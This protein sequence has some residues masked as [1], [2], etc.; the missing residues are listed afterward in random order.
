MTISAFNCAS[1]D[2]N[3]A[4]PPITSRSNNELGCPPR[5]C[6]SLF[7]LQCMHLHTGAGDRSPDIST[8]TWPRANK[9]T[10]PRLLNINGSINALRG[11]REHNNLP[12]ISPPLVFHPL[13]ESYPLVSSAVTSSPIKTC[14]TWPGSV[15]RDWGN[16][17]RAEN[18]GSYYVLIHKQ[19]P[20][21]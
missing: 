7:Q 8:S 18:I 5:L 21:P 13:L 6:F 4:K 9:P 1:Q 19:C 10:H 20:A 2:Y 15:N 12:F 14:C 3:A 16:P 11:E 17:G